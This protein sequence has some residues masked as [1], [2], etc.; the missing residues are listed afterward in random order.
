ME[1]FTKLQSIIT[2]FIEELKSIDYWW[3]LG[4]SAVSLGLAIVIH[5]YYERYWIDVLKRENISNIHERGLTTLRRIILPI[6]TL[7]FLLV[8][9][10]LLESLSLPAS[11]FIVLVPLAIS[12]ATIRFLVYVLRITF[13]SSPLEHA[14]ENVLSS[15]IWLLVLLHITGLL[16][17]TRDALDSVAFSLGDTRISIM[18]LVKFIVVITMMFILST[19][20]T[21]VIERQLKGSKILD[22][23]MQV[24]IAKTS[25][26]ILF[27]AAFLISLTS[28]GIDLTAFAVFSGAL[29]VGIGFGLQR[30][31]SN[32]ISGFILV[33]DGSIRPGDVITVDNNFGWVQELR[34]RYMVVRNRD[35]LETLIPNETFITKE[36][37]NWSHS[38]R[39][40]RL[41]I[42]IQIS[43]QSDPERAMELMEQAGFETKRVLHDPAPA[44][45]LVEFADSGITLELRLWISDPENGVTNVRSE[46]SLAIWKMFRAHNIEIPYPHREIIIKN[47]QDVAKLF[48]PAAPKED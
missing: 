7:V 14:G 3:Q 42:Q 10:Y 37:V 2:T 47:S 15:S 9:Q 8:S 6:M 13:P 34:A 25:K 46:A 33:F 17:P 27:T 31:A 11:L 12:L 21:G 19:W 1:I 23:S 32:F 18:S 35:G 26:F 36:V 48:Q 22:V 38:D 30:I 45:R 4:L 5:R 20:L 29:G 16:E 41:K 43:Y 24:G 39:Q 44:S 28:V 40:V